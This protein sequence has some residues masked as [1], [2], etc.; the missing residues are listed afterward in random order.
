MDASV[1]ITGII[2][3]AVALL[4]VASLA[5]L[6]IVGGA[7]YIWGNPQSTGELTRQAVV[8]MPGST[9]PATGARFSVIGADGA[10][11][12]IDTRPAA[13]APT[14]PAAPGSISFAP[15]FTF[16]APATAP[17]PG[18]GP[19]A[20]TLPT[21]TIA[22]PVAGGPV[23]VTVGPS[24][25]PGAVVYMDQG[26]GFPAIGTPVPAGGATFNLAAPGAPTTFSA[27]V[28]AGG[29]TSAPV[30]VNAT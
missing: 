20:A 24:T 23:I 16:G 10:E 3:F 26:V 1:M 15:V 25:A 9:I 30:S 19:A 7:R 5:A 21:V 6:A 17:T 13:P 28:A 14:A 4:G 22:Q 18:P 2:C 27:Y 29:A 12:F 8:A 11:V